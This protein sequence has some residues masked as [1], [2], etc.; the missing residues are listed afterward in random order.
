M[1]NIV[2][3]TGQSADDVEHDTYKAY[4]YCLYLLGRRF[5]SVE[6]INRKLREKR[7]DREIIE[8]IVSLL[9]DEGFLDDG[10]FAEAWVRDRIN[11]KPRGR[12]MLTRELKQRGVDDCII[13]KVL[14]GE[15]PDDE[16]GLA[17]RAIA[18]K[19]QYYLALRRDIGVRRV[20]GFLVRR[21][22]AFAT[23]RRII[24]E[25]FGK[26]DE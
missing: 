5:Y 6:E 19:K 24:D 11:F 2:N 12:V 18:P 17:R 15:Y 7:Y 4:N 20:K 16:T 9:E 1:I 21:G 26:D 14:D 25:I 3:E 10:R 22:F 13:D 8:A 23:V